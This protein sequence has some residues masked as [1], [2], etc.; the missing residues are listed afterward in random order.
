VAEG[1]IGKQRTVGTVMEKVFIL[2]GAAHLNSFH[3]FP[4]AKTFT[5]NRRVGSSSGRAP[6][7]SCL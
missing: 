5:S 7:A 1:Q 4:L 2:S 3:Y 6:A